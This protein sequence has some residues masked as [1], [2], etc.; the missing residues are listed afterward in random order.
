MKLNLE[1]LNSTNPQL[2]ACSDA[3]IRI[4]A[5]CVKGK[6]LDQKMYFLYR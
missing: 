6:N 4:A 3:K 2:R 5:V 1:P